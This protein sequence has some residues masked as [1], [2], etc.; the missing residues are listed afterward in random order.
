MNTVEG[1]EVSAVAI[2]GIDLGT[3]NSL[4]A[5]WKDGATRLI[6][7]ALGQYL[8]PSAVS[9]D[10]DGTVLVGQAA[11]DRLVSHPER[12]AASFK[13]YMGTGR[14][15]TLG[16]RSF[17]PEELSALVL[18]QLR[19]DA[20]AYLS[21]PVTEAV[22]SVPAYFGEA[23]RA[24]T[25]QAGQ[26]AGMKVERLV[27][28]P[29]AA[30]L[31][32]RLSDLGRDGT[33]LVFDLGGGTL[34]VSVVDC[35]ENVVSVV[36]VAG[37]NSLGGDDFDRAI[38]R[39]FCRENGAELEELSPIQRASVLRLAEQCKRV[40]EGQRAAV[41]TVLGEDFSGSLTL[42]RESLVELAAGEFLR[43]KEPVRRALQD[44]ALPV[45]EVSQLILVGGSCRMAVIRQYLTQLLGRAPLE[46]G[47][48]DTVVALGVGAYAGIKERHSGV[49]EMVLTDICPFTLG[50]GVMNHGD[51]E[52]PL[53]SPIIERNSVLPSSKVRRYCTAWDGQT[54]LDIQ[55][56]Q[57]EELYAK[58]NSPLGCVSIPL[59]AA[60]AGREA[61]DVRFTYDING[62]LEVEVTGVSTG[63]RRKAVLL[64]RSGMS[65]AEA[66]K[67]L[68]ELE[69]L[70]AHPRTQRR[71]RA[72][73]ARGE[74]LFRETL[75]PLRDQVLQTLEHFQRALETQEQ[76]Q[77]ERARRRAVAFLDR[78]E[79]DR[80]WMGPYGVDPEELDGL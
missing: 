11:K 3:T 44:S 13:R 20:E 33:Y 34:D 74:R 37:D 38:A 10:A 23:Q 63:E 49:G 46:L 43:L 56:F 28:E 48:P 31:A 51:A 79:E 72:V 1:G 41:L 12:S 58:E 14:R 16:D 53:L 7:N 21:E 26:L 61:A 17:T 68:A 15:F 65:Q 19:E 60:P 47:D 59:P 40:L 25:K 18:R 39:R 70:K 75:G 29:S 2:I 71:N 80:A 73:L 62:L 42:T 64:G 54:Q 77:I 9:L 8:T 4:A 78:A 32:Y 36:A 24:A 35:F 57:G 6:P 52:H 5:V 67:R 45:G 55:V 66:E 76:G 30:A 27:N 22:V 50:T 69:A